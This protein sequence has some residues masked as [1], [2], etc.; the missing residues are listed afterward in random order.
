MPNTL[1]A[2]KRYLFRA[3]MVCLAGMFTV[4]V[5]LSFFP[6]K[7][8][9]DGVLLIL[10]GGTCPGGLYVL[11]RF[12]DKRAE[13]RPARMDPAKLVD[14]TLYG[15]IMLLSPAVFLLALGK[16]LCLLHKLKKEG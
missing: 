12:M 4:S 2:L 6:A 11:A 7:T 16:G 10:L 1:E 5:F 13:A 3:W 8:S 15:A 9:L 14:V